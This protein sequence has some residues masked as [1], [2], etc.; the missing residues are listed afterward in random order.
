MRLFIYRISALLMLTVLML[1]PGL[2][3]QKLEGLKKRVAVVDFEDRAR[4]G[5]NIGRGIADMLVTSLV[6]SGKFSVIE[7]EQL[8]AVLAEQGLGLS[9]AVTPQSAAQ[10][11]KLLGVELIVTGSVSEFGEKKS[12]IGGSI[13]GIGGKLSSRKARSVVDLRLVNTTTGEIVMAETAEGESSSKSLD[14]VS[15]SDIDF[16]NPT[17]WDQ[18]ILGKAARES[19]E[20]SVDMI[21]K[22]MKDIPWSGKIIKANDDGT[23][24]MKPGSEG[25]VE[26]GMEFAVYS[27]GEELI[28]PD[29]GISL[30]SEEKMIGR[31]K[32][33]SDVGDGKA[34]KAIVVSGS[35]FSA[36]D[37][38][39]IK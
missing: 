11:G 39:R 19:V 36:S 27:Q 25:G 17:S 5:H 31:I 6:K 38:V 32:V 15:F 22:A 21:E 4:Y 1:A 2:Y 33:V 30:G 12:S 20:K 18:T 9:G 24:Y 26:A 3:A 28:D 23:V 29:T 13:P 37:I 8:D 35:G 16:G 14:R 10:V 7:R 34:C